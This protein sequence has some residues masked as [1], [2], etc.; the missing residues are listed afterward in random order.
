LAAGGIPDVCGRFTLTAPP[1]AL[2]RAFGLAAVP[3]LAPRYNVAPGQ[4]VATVAQTEAGQ[5][6]LSLR[7]WGLVPYWAK[8][9]KLGARL[10]NARAETAH[11]KPAYRDAFARRRCLV[12]A[13]GFFEWADTRAG[14]RQPWWVTRPDGGCFGMAGL[15]E[16]WQGPQGEWLETCVI[17]TSAAAPR[18]AALHDRMPVIL[19]PS[20]WALW[21]DPELRDPER[22]RALLRP[23]GGR[24]ELRP[25]SPRVNRP[26]HDDPGCIAPVP[27]APQGQ[28]SLFS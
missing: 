7:R 23:C 27:E 24:F 28:R 6:V 3:E 22:V 20:D 21:L 9:A 14:A 11:L 10:V 19:A 8:D 2:R 17:L 25:V 4:D 16:R 12:P 26:E 18:L 15:Y 1:D 13:D 5:R